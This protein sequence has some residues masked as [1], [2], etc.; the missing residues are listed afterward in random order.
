M[1]TGILISVAAT[2][3]FSFTPFSEMCWKV[4]ANRD[5]WT[6][7]QVASLPIAFFPPHVSNTMQFLKEWLAAQPTDEAYLLSKTT[8]SKQQGKLSLAT[9]NPTDYIFFSTR[10]S[11]GN[12]FSANLLA[13]N[14]QSFFQVPPTVT[15]VNNISMISS[16]HT[17]AH[18]Y[19]W[20]LRLHSNYFYPMEATSAPV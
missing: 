19:T 7:I 15:L 16:I 9:Q 1:E 4:A 13:K 10:L 11:N 6:S 17:A 3:L 8:V 5:S 14:S 20:L 2:H 12:H 18:P